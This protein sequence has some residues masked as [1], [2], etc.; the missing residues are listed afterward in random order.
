MSSAQTILIGVAVVG[1]T[2]F[3]FM[4]SDEN[5]YAEQ[6]VALDSTEAKAALAIFKQLSQSTNALADESKSASPGVGVAGAPSPRF[7]ASL[8]AYFA[9]MPPAASVASLGSGAAEA[10]G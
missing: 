5:E 6:V 8:A 2:V 9:A 4:R 7:A 1:I 3:G 10:S